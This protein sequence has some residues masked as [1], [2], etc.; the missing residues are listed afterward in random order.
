MPFG[1]SNALSTLQ[2]LMNEVFRPHLRK[3]IL[4]FFDDILSYNISWESHL[5]YF[6]FAFELLRTHHLNV[7]LGRPKLHKLGIL[8]LLQE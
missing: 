5:L 7:S 8:F 6:Y 4:V 2:A 1:L 3:F